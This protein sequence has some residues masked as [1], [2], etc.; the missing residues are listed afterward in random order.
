MNWKIKFPGNFSLKKL[1]YNKRFTIPFSI[2]M[3]FIIW[4]IIMISQ[5]PN[6]ERTFTNIPVNINLD[7]TF[8]SEN[9]LEITDDISIQKFTVSVKGPS[10]V[11]SS[12]K[13]G[14]FYVYASAA[15]V[16]APGEYQLEVAGGKNTVNT[17][18]D[19]ISITPSV[20]NVNFDYVDTKEFTV[21]TNAEGAGAVEGLIAEK[22][23]VGG[24]ESDII[25]IKGPRSVINKIDSVV[26]YSAVNKALSQT[27]TFDA[28]IR[29]YDEN[30][31]RI[32]ISNLVLSATNVKLTVPISKSTTVP[33][34]AD[35]TNLPS[36]F[37][38]SSISYK[39]NHDKV[40][41]IGTPE[42]IDKITQVTLSAIDITRISATSNSFDV[43]AKLPDGVRLLDTIEQFT[44]VI[45][46]SAYEEKTFNITKIKYDKLANGL[47]A[48]SDNV[49]RNVRIC[50]PKSVIRRLKDTML[51]AEVDLSD[52]KAGEHTV[53]VSVKSDEFNNIWQVGS[54]STTV[55]IK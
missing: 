27:E 12:L 48:E 45:D 24:I 47:N 26:A 49:I 46:T 4:L 3:A 8:A 15:A 21:K 35:F 52:K 28:E 22:P 34:V 41:V 42:T 20:V 44:V 50:G 30:G 51:Y 39:V 23:V 5:N 32:S 43:S 10:Y 40:T 14:D 6:I 38:K 18:Y 2:V 13:S 7:N 36:G 9:G 11:I 25:T 55:K 16:N 33:V 1:L 19:I 54:Y 53:L 29:L 37:S 31:A 17:D